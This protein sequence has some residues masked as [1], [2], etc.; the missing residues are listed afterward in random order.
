MTIGALL[1]AAGASRRMG[2]QKLLIPLGGKPMVA[3]VA[4]AARA[5][6]LPLLLVT[7]GDAD[8]VRAAAGDVAAVHADRHGL[9]L[10]E[11][12]K[13]GLRAAPAGWDG[14]LVLLGDMPKV[15][16]DTLR[17]LAG[18]LAGAEMV[19]PVHGGRRGNPAGFARRRWPDLLALEGDRGARDLLA[20]AVA[21]PVDDAGVLV[22]Y[23][24]PEDTIS[25]DFC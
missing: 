19:V 18:A 9:G 6:G 14:L 16:P 23:D 15:R 22:D 3:H 7:G 12:L 25:A 8:A 5:A 11:S 1:L 2:R 24:V 4:E 20:D 17:S 10:A 21:V 13:A